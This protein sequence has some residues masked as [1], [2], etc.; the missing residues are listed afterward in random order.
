MRNGGLLR[1][2]SKK[3]D[4]QGL[5]RYYLILVSVICVFEGGVWGEPYLEKAPSGR[6]SVTAEDG[7]GSTTV[8]RGSD[9]E[10]SETEEYDD[11]EGIIEEEFPE[12]EWY[13]G[14]TSKEGA[15]GTVQEEKSDD[16]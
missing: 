5:F 8:E 13:E 12:D 16:G 9:D 11:E 4:M 6:I 1:F 7:E 3:G 15:T 2:V 10:H 14:N